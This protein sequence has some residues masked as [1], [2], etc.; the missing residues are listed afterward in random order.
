M[1]HEPLRHRP[2]CRANE[3]R[4]WRARASKWL[5]VLGCVWVSFIILLIPSVDRLILSFVPRSPSS[6]LLVA[7]LVLSLVF[8]G[9]PK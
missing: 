3:R 8:S 5:L 1:Y 7:L 6:E 9:R 4:R 2:G